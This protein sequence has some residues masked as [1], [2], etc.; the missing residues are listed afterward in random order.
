MNKPRS[1]APIDQAARALRERAMATQPGAIIGSEDEI[2][3]QLGVSRV[4]VRQAARLLEREGVLLVKRGKKG[5]YFSARPSVGMVEEVVCAYLDT[6]GISASHTGGVATALWVEAVREATCADREAARAAAADLVALV[7][8]IG[9]DATMHDISRAE[10]AFRSRVFDL[11]DGDYMRTIF[12]INAAFAR[13]KIV[14]SNASADP[15]LH[16]RFLRKWR[17]GKL[18]Q[19][20]AIAGGDSLQGTLAAL[21]ERNAWI[22]RQVY[23]TSRID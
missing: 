20:E 16:A 18:L 5:G 4:T 15:E 1:L 13:K 6:L 21:H 17:S 11:I 12:Q 23:T 7:E 14:S 9:P 2:V 3:E 22:E 10:A 19:A 8:A